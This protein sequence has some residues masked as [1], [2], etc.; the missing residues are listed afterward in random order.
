M[1]ASGRVGAPTM[2]TFDS[3]E[4]PPPIPFNCRPFGSGLPIAARKIGAHSARGG[5]SFAALSSMGLPALNGFIGEFTILL[6]VANVNIWWATF[7]SVGI[8]LGAAYLLWLY[9]RVFWGPLDNPANKNVPDLNGRELSLLVALVVV[10]VWI[11]IYPG[12]FF[13]MLDEP[14]NYVVTKV[15]PQYFVR[16]PMESTGSVKAADAVHRPAQASPQAVVAE[17]GK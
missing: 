16:H 14:V 15:D 17:K 6:G 3:E 10:M 4:I 12:T 8:V 7:A 13:S 9:Q 5:K 11:G 1:S 2:H